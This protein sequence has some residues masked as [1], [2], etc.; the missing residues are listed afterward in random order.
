MKNYKMQKAPIRR[1]L[2]R[3]SDNSL[4]DQ[5]IEIFSESKYALLTFPEINKIFWHFFYRSVSKP[6]GWRISAKAETG[7]FSN[8]R[9][10]NFLY[11]YS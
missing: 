6:K 9:R 11:G 4:S 10:W 2:F 3:F 1:D 7:T 8:F 5:K